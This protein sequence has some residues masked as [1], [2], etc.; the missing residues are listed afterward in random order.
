MSEV[1]VS[2]NRVKALASFLGCEEDEITPQ[3]PWGD[4]KIAVQFDAPGGEYLVLTDGEASF[5]A[6]EKI[7]ESAWCFQPHF[8]KSHFREEVFENA[9]D[10]DELMESLAEVTGRLC[11][12]AN[13]L[14]KALI[15]DK[16]E[17]VQDAIEADGRGHFISGYDGEE[18]EELVKGAHWEAIKGVLSQYEEDGMIT[19]AI[20]GCDWKEAAPVLVCCDW[21]MEDADEETAKDV[22]EIRAWM[23]R[24]YRCFFIYRVN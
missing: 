2:E 10:E 22:E 11:E 21:L 8:L 5:L 9:G 20:Q 15:A 4:D 1:Y 23:G 17:F 7:L 16:N 3:I 18:H 14:I 13:G 6:K 19:A 24:G 12:S